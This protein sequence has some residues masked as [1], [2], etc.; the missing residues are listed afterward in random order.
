MKLHLYEFYLDDGANPDSK[1]YV[2]SSLE[3]NTTRGYSRIWDHGGYDADVFYDVI[4]YG[5][6]R[7]LTELEDDLRD[8]MPYCT[9][10]RVCKELA[11]NGGDFLDL[12]TDIQGFFEEY[13]G[14]EYP[15]E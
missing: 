12:D 6:V 4:K 13:Y 8:I 1:V 10:E 14:K 2:I 11:V 7:E 15:D 5:E 9:D 3:P